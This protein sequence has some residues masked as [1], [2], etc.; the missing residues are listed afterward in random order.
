MPTDDDERDDLEEF[1]AE[2]AQSD[3]EFPALVEAALQ[4]RLEAIALGEDPH[5]D[6]DVGRTAD[7]GDKQQVKTQETASVPD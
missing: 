6:E 5:G 2:C 1:I 3:P 4:R 7:T